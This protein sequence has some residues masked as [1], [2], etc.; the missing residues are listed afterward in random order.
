MKNSY[1]PYSLLILLFCCATLLQAQTPLTPPGRV[2]VKFNAK[3]PQQAEKASWQQTSEGYSASFSEQ[4]RPTVSR[5]SAEGRWLGTDTQLRQ[6]D[7]P[8]TATQYLQD[9]HKGFR[10]LQGYRYE[11]PN[12]SRYQ[13]DVESAGKRYR[14]D[15]D[16]KGN[17]VNEGPLK[18]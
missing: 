2:S 18:E 12:G 9:N 6:A 3:Y 16:G 15:F 7:L 14:L 11:S 4:G 10:Y 1:K 8:P 5:F 13:L 17:F